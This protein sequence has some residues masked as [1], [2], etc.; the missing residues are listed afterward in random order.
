MYFPDGSSTARVEEDTHCAG[1]HPTA[2]AVAQDAC[3]S[4]HDNCAI[5][6]GER[7]SEAVLIVAGVALF[8]Q[9]SRTSCGST[10]KLT[11][12]ELV[13]GAE[14]V[15]DVFDWTDLIVVPKGIAELDGPCW[16]IASP[17]IDALNI[18]VEAVNV[19]PDV[20]VGGVA[21]DVSSLRQ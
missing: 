20:P 13:T 18:G 21:P 7:K 8:L 1:I 2:A 17:I 3:S 11:R 4:A 12:V 5:V 14:S 15:T 9:K 10:T 16:A 19:V 6:T